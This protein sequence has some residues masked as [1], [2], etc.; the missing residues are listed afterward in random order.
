MLRDGTWEMKLTALSEKWLPEVVQRDLFLY[1]L[2]EMPLLR[3][4]RARGLRKGQTLAFRFSNGSG[5]IVLDSEAVAAP[6]RARRRARLHRVPHARRPDR[7]QRRGAGP[8]LGS[9]AGARVAGGR[10]RK[11]ATTAST[12]R[13]RSR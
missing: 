4:V 8:P 2:E 9:R 7:G 6:R 10:W 13:A 11:R 5:E 3:E 12:R 1:G